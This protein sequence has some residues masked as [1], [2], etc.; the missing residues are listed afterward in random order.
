[1]KSTRLHLA[2]GIKLIQR[3]LKEQA[4]FFA[5]LVREGFKRFAGASWFKGFKTSFAL[6]QEFNGFKT[7]TIKTPVKGISLSDSRSPSSDMFFMC[8]HLS[9]YPLQ[10]CTLLT[11]GYALVRKN[12]GSA[13][14]KNNSK[15]KA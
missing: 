15:Y 11:S 10:S 2:K 14:R 5:S 4:S 1:M 8:K 6:V 9:P 7:K 12:P 13:N 3:L